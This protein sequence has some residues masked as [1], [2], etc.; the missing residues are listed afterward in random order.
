MAE[1]RSGDDLAGIFLE[2]GLR[3]VKEGGVRKG[4]AKKTTKIAALGISLCLLAASLASAE[5]L[6]RGNL[7]V[8]TTASMRPTRLPRE[9]A[10]PIAVAVAGHI[11]TTDGSRPPQ[12]SALQIAINRHGRLDFSGLPTCRIEQIQPASSERALAACRS[13]LVGQ[14]KFVGTIALP[15]A[16]PYPIEG[17]LLLFNGEESRR[18]VLFGHIYADKPFATSFVMTFAIESLRRGT[19]GTLLSANLRKALGN[20][21][22]L[23]G[24]EMT[25]SRRWRSGGRSHSYLSAGCPAPRG[26]G[27]AVFP[28]AKTTFSFADG[29][30][31]SQTLRRN[32]RAR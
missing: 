6:Q 19:Y 14:G 25:L 15:G 11:A 31:F 1:P 29:R 2:M 27:G 26:F 18:R 16:A 3:E 10:A 28:L 8:S 17:R 9:G 22:N 20:K 4:E 30:R 23:T 32:C 12:L 24:I 21:R 7:R 5:I 13:S